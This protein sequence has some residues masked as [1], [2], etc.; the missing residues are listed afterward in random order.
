MKP[1]FAGIITIIRIVILHANGYTM[2]IMMNT[3]KFVGRNVINMWSRIPEPLAV[4]SWRIYNSL[5]YSLKENMGFPQ[6]WCELTFAQ[7]DFVMA[8]ID[9]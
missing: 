2:N 9:L 3:K 4:K 1:N 7:Q 8:L 5:P 6:N